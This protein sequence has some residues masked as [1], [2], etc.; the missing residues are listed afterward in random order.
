MRNNDE[1]AKLVTSGIEA[2]DV[3]VDFNNRVDAVESRQQQPLPAAYLPHILPNL[4]IRILHSNGI[5]LYFPSG[6]I[7]LFT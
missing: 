1:N 3:P 7:Q 4:P 6:R 5:P 2:Y